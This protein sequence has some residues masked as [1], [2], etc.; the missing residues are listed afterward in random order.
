MIIGVVLMK[1]IIVFLCILVS[2]SLLLVDIQKASAEGTGKN[3]GVNIGN[4]APDFILKDM[5][6]QKVRLSDLK[7]KKVMINFW[8]TWC[9][10]CRQEMPEIEKFFQE[11]KGDIEILA[12]NIDGGAPKNVAD[13][14]K[15][16]KLTF[17]VVLD[18]QDKV[19]EMYKVITIPTTFLID[20]KGVIVNKYYS[21]MSLE[22]MRELIRKK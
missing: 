10:P 5:K 21:V 1:K 15:K 18:E 14:I 22:I 9:P 20:E 12:I 3:I 8:A 16:M 19:N 4:I 2:V 13:Y 6:G 11:Q 17:P 7:G